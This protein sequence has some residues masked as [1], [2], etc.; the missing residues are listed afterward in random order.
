MNSF[1]KTSKTLMAFQ[2]IC[3]CYLKKK[4]LSGELQVD[5]IYFEKQNI[6]LDSRKRDAKCACLCVC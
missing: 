3:K 1:I 2:E 6:A 4:P 5:P